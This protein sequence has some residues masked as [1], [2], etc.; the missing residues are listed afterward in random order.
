MK[1]HQKDFPGVLTVNIDTRID[2]MDV[3]YSESWHPDEHLKEQL[4]VV[5]VH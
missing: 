5:R 2:E 3:G 4:Y 1:M